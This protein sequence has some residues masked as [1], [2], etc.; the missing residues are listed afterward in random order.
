MIVVF[1]TVNI[2]SRFHAGKMMPSRARTRSRGQCQVSIN[3]TLGAQIE[4]RSPLEFERRSIEVH[5]KW[6][7]TCSRFGYK[8]RRSA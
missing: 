1:A 8:K 6:F 3:M 2:T 4:T 5:L 7:E